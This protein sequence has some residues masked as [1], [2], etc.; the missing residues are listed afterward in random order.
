MSF[1][2]K[3]TLNSPKHIIFRLNLLH[4]ATLDYDSIASERISDSAKAEYPLFE[5]Q[6][7]LKHSLQHPDREVRQVAINILQLLY[8]RYGFGEIE[9][10]TMQLHP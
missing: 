3:A 7:M 6:E 8:D 4:R 2:N 10:I 5:V 1:F 9:V